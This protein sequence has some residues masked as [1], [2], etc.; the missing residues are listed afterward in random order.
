LA[1]P[2]RIIPD[3]T[4]PGIV[5]LH[6]KR[7]RFALPWCEGKD[8]LDVACGVG[9]GS[10]VLAERAR[11][12]VGIDRDEAA[13]A[14]AHSRYGGENVEFRV[15]DALAL[16]EPAGTYDVVCS[17]ETIEHVPDQERFLAGIAR[18]LRPDGVFVVSTPHVPTTTRNP[19]NP[20]H[21]VELSRADFGE[22]L[23]RHF[24]DVELYGQR[25]LQSSSHRVLQRL[26]VLGLRK[27]LPFLRRASVITGTRSTESLTLDDVVIDREEIDRATELVGVCRFPAPAPAKPAP[28]R[29]SR[30]GAGEAGASA[31]RP[32]PSSL[33]PP[34]GSV[35]PTPPTLI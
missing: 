23:A 33:R 35:E 3:E 14:Y 32:A 27:R 24:G 31:P 28:P 13:I 29:S 6:L 15:G 17:F 5:A 9:Y 26:D 20:F 12:V 2:E 8:V 4:E 19:D 25:R 11:R 22:L 16:D 18:V 34:G 10:V 30:S 21:E 1:Y 7:Y